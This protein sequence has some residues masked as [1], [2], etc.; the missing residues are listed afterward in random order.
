MRALALS[1][2]LAVAG[3]SPA[4]LG[5]VDAAGPI[6]A[7]PDARADG[8]AD[9]G[10]TEQVH[11]VGR[12]DLS[13]PSA[14]SFSFPG[15]AVMATFD[16]TGVDVDLETNGQDTFAIVIDGALSRTVKPPQGRAVRPLANGLAAGRHDVALYKRTES[17]VGVARFRGFSVHDGALVATPFPFPHRIEIVG[18]SIS[19]GY[20]AEG[21]GPSCPFVADQET[22]FGAWGAVAARA[23]GAA[24]STV[25]YSGKGLTRNY[26]GGTSVLMGEIWQRTLGDMPNP[27][28][29]FASTPAPDVV[30]IN[31][32]TN[33]FSVGDPGK[34]FE[35]AYLAM[36]TDVRSRYPS[37]WIVCAAGTML[38]A[39]ELA[40]AD[41]YIQSAVARLG[42]KRVSTLDLG[43]QQQSDGIGCDWH[44]SLA[45]QQK[46]GAALA[47]HIK[48]VMGW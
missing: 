41:A 18:D 23:L 22:E 43:V 2:G 37:A 29:S 19:C 35:D 26:G 20:G 21:Q 44:P 28:W 31:L 3:C 25:C 15:T 4:A 42:D 10:P 13:D 36:L 17:F 47:A 40:K 24:R 27:R 7:A 8:G 11:F 12:F 5:P 34:A 46:M 45:T 33:D 38:G 16:G 14:P 32:G 30:V 48:S 39:S 6:D 1:L 9:A